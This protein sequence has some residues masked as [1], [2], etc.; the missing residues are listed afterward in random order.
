MA[1]NAKGVL[2]QTSRTWYGV[3]VDITV[4]S[5]HWHRVVVPGLALPHPGLVNLFARWGLPV[6][7]RLALTCRH[8][9][10]HLQTLPVPLA[11]LLLITLAAPWPERRLPLAAGL[12]WARRAPGR[13]GTCRRELC[14]DHH[15]ARPPALAFRDRPGHL[16][17][18]VERHRLS[19]RRRDC[20]LDAQAGIFTDC[21]FVTMVRYRAGRP[22]PRTRDTETF[23]FS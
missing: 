17:H 4:S 22:H 20:F 9:F 19:C 12:N 18:P 15:Q 13:L 2:H 6:D 10:G 8:E 7:E 16:C 1:E 5:D 3:P 23:G 14:R 21:R 11:H